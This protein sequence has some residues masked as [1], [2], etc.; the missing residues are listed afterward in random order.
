MDVFE[1]Q[2]TSVITDLVAINLLIKLLQSLDFES[3]LQIDWHSIRRADGL[4]GKA[5]KDN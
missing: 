2:P 4:K 3:K 5:I 1:L